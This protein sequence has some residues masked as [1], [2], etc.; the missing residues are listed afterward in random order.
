MADAAAAEAKS[1]AK[2]TAGQ[3]IKL[4]VDEAER[5]IEARVADALRGA[6]EARVQN[7]AII[8]ERIGILCNHEQTA[9]EFLLDWQA[10]GGRTA[11]ARRGCRPPDFGCSRSSPRSAASRTRGHAR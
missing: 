6:L 9:T 2:K 8:L 11:R 7:L 4:A 10:R 1:G 3:A 5:A